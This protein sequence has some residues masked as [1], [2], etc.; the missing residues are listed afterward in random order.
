MNKL[1]W[2]LHPEILTWKSLLMVKPLQYYISLT[3]LADGWLREEISILSTVLEYDYN[4][5]LLFFTIYILK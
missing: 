4:L 5:L 3:F 2:V 1:D